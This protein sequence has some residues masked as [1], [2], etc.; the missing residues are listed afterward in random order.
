MDL[1]ATAAAAPV[2]RLERVLA[3]GRAF[4]TV[5]A[6]IA[7]YLDPTQPARLA[8]VTYTVLAAYAVYSV[9]V[10]VAVQRA[11]RV[12]ATLGL[13]LHGL[14]ILWTAALTF[15]SEG[16]VS[17]FFLFFLF[18]VLAAAYRWGFGGTIA[19]AGITIAVFLVETA[20]A[21]AGPW[22]QTWFASIG[23]ELNRTILRVTYL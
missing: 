9:A 22:S 13:L 12:S 19:T 21:A 17:P 10:W 16:P 11:R 6:L 18:V 20:I 4:L 7:I 5:T 3:V 23:F 14:D 2:T 15:V 8:A 1:T